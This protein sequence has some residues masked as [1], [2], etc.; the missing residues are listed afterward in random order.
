MGIYQASNGKF[1]YSFMASGKLAHK[2]REH[3]TLKECVTKAEAKKYCEKRQ[4]AVEAMLDGIIPMD[5]KVKTWYDNNVLKQK[6]KDNSIITVEYMCNRLVKKAEELNL[7]TLEKIKMHA[8]EIKK[9]FGAERDVKDIEDTDINQFLKYISNTHLNK[10]G[11]TISNST[12]NRY[13]SSIR[14]AFNIL[15]TDKKIDLWINPCMNIKKKQE[16]KKKKMIL[17]KENEEKFFNSFTSEIQRDIYMLDLQ[18]GFRISNILNLN[19]PQIDI[20]NRRI[21]IEPKDNKGRKII[22]KKINNKAFEIIMKY[23]DKAEYYLFLN[24]VTGKPF[25]SL[26]KSFK[27]SAR[28]AGIEGLTPHD[29]RR[30]F[31]TRIYKK[32]KDIDLARKALDHTSI[33]TSMRYIITD[34]S[35]VDKAMEEI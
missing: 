28:K 31:G 4:K 1:R 29:I 8:N 3:S 17:A 27:N 12:E 11:K 15:I 34:E 10:K 32:T 5:E 30:T 16:V 2:Y 26:R 7:S 18:L 20:E 35:E 19:K 24:P 14:R 22:D 23:Y 33:E 25:K 9:Y 13:L 6:I 21:R